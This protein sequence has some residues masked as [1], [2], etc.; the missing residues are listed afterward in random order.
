[1]D[2][3]STNFDQIEKDALDALAGAADSAALEKWRVACL[4]AA[5]R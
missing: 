4:D 3:M 1:V 5:P 2:T